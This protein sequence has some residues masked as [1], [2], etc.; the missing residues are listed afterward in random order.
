MRRNEVKKILTYYCC[1]LCIKTQEK[2]K[3]KKL[4]KKIFKN[5]RPT[6]NYQNINI[7]GKKYANI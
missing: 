7:H 3:K 2:L 6:Q 5:V 4:L 1:N